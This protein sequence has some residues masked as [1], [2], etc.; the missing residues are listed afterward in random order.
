MMNSWISGLMVF[1]Y[2]VVAMKANTTGEEVE[3]AK[4]CWHRSL[5]SIALE[6]IRSP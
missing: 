6:T 1:D 3:W 4:A 5:M 2:M